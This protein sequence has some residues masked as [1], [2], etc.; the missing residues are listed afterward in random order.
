MKFKMV[1]NWLNGFVYFVSLLVV[2]SWIFLLE[3]FFEIVMKDVDDFLNVE[4]VFKSGCVKG[5]KFFVEGFI[6]EF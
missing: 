1:D 5:Y 3:W 2:F 6:Y 4:K